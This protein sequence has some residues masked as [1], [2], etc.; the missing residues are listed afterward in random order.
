[1][2]LLIQSLH[3]VDEHLMLM[4]AEN[5]DERLC[6]IPENLSLKRDVVIHLRQTLLVEVDQV[7]KG[8]LTNIKSRK[9]WQKIISNEKTEENEIVDD[10]L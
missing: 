8:P 7:V 4:L 6:S 9:R 1:M 5:I 10:S 3:S 2:I